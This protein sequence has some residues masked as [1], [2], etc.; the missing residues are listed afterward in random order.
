MQL[1][2]FGTPAILVAFFKGPPGNSA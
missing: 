2:G 1:L